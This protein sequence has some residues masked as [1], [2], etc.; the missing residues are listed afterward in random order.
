MSSPP[1]MEFILRDLRESQCARESGHADDRAHE[2][3]TPT[4]AA[5][6]RIR[7]G[8]MQATDMQSYF[9]AAL[10]EVASAGAAAQSERTAAGRTD[11]A[12]IH[13]SSALVYVDV[14]TCIYIFIHRVPN[15]TTKTGPSE[16][17]SPN[18]F[19]CI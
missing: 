16:Q 14:Y 17:K 7:R 9:D 15:R 10:N 11:E 1:L 4:G 12:H 19:W 3:S 5:L 13:A 2:L 8:E 18:V 6:N